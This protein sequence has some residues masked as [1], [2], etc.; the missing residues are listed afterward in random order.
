MGVHYGKGVIFVDYFQIVE[1]QNACRK[2]WDGY[3]MFA[4]TVAVARSGFVLTGTCDEQAGSGD[5]AEMF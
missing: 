1:I 5:F 2:I 4:Q 3:K